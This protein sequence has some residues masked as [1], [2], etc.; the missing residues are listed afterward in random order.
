MSE[1]PAIPE[2]GLYRHYKGGLY[3]LRFL[4]IEESKGGQVCVYQSQ[5]T[6]KHYVRPVEDW[7]TP[8]EGPG[9]S[10]FTRCERPPP[11]SFRY[12]SPS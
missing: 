1:T 2:A 11:G 8:M 3:V 12:G 9:H 7:F 5:Q 6:G 10:R 4:A